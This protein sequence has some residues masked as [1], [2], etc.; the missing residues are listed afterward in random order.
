MVRVIFLCTWIGISILNAASFDC[1]KASSH[2][3]KMICSDA[4]ISSL[5]SKLGRIYRSVLK[6][7]PSINIDDFKDEGKI[8]IKKR[9][10]CKN[11]TCLVDL[12]TTRIS[13]LQAYP[14]HHLPGVYEVTSQELNIRDNPNKASNI[15]G[16]AKRGGRGL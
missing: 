6:S 7:I 15:L 5:D 14:P 10:K 9:N 16:R 4:E 11:G 3:D 1:S 8:W 13:Y 2:V 12:Y